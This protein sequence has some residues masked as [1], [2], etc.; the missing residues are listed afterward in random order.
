MAGH[1]YAELKIPFAA[2]DAAPPAPGERW[3]LHI[4]RFRHADGGETSSWVCMFGSVH[5][6]DLAGPL[7]FVG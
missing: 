1:W 2:L 7:V 5:R 3:N 4:I 6:N